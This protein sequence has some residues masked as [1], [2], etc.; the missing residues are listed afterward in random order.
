MIY[1][2]FWVA[3]WNPDKDPKAAALGCRA[4]VGKWIPAENEKFALEIFKREYPNAYNVVVQRT[5]S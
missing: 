1:S 5:R 3:G 4:S 2:S